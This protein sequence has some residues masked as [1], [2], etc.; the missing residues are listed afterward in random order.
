MVLG[1][2]PHPRSALCMGGNHGFGSSRETPEL[3][4]ATY[5]FDGFTMTCDSGTATNMMRKSNNEE[6]N[7]TK[8]PHWPTNNERIEIYGTRQL[9]YLGRHGI[10]WQVVETDGKI[11]AE[12][13][14]VHPDKW[15]QPDF[16]ECIRTRRQPNADI[17]QA[18]YSACL[19]HLANTS[20]RVG[21]R[22]LLF[23]GAGE[24]FT[25]SDAANALS[26]PSYRP[27]YEV[28][29]PV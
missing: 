9:M 10:G 1:D 26:K 15:H 11:V 21:G 18:H 17:E 13:K 23:D 29:D 22:H 14:G 20:Y 7:G 24:R 25:N 6:R 4:C 28:P 12:D 27:G 16:V 2:P 19:V 8:W 3:Q 5:E